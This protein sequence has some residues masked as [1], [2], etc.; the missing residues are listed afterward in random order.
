MEPLTVAQAARDLGVTGRR[1]RMLIAAGRLAARITPTGYRIR[2]A[3]LD[4]VRVRKV[5]RPKGA[6][7]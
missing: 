6:L 2:A 3:D 4:S 1:V 5:G 7:E